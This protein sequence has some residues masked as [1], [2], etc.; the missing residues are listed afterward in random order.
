MAEIRNCIA[1]N[2]PFKI[3]PSNPDRKCCSRK[4]S[5]SLGW[6][7]KICPQCS[8]EFTRRKSRGTIYCSIRCATS[9]I[10]MEKNLGVVHIGPRFCEQCGKEISKG[11]KW[12]GVRFCSRK[13]FGQY[14]ST[15]LKGKPR[16]EVSGP[17]PERYKRIE[18]TCPQCNKIFNIKQCFAKWQ[19]ESEIYSG[20]N[21]FNWRGGY[22]P[23]YGPNWRQQQRN[24]RHRDNYTCQ[25][26]GAEENKLRKQLDVHHIK[27]FRLFGI[28][29][30]K[31]AN[32]LSNLIC[33]CPSC[34]L[35]IEHEQNG[36]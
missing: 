35:R 3:Y 15:T 1:C 24:A 22:S 29:N 28:E 7:T 19:S 31:Q 16:P 20:E 26:C 32:R 14:L 8:Q 9:R 10:G 36:R 13:C 21:N 12:N 27:P 33:L 5:D 17:H 30:Y 23:Y 18:K 25:S 11:K 6:I 2:K 4:C 34:H